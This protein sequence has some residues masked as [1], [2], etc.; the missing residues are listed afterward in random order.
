MVYLLQE[1]VLLRGA[2]E[3]AAQQTAPGSCGHSQNPPRF[4]LVYRKFIGLDSDFCN[5][6]FWPQENQ[7]IGVLE[8]GVRERGG[9]QDCRFFD[10]P[11]LVSLHFS[12]RQGDA[13]SPQRET[14][15]AFAFAEVPH[16][17]ADADSRALHCT[18]GTDLHIESVPR[19]GQGDRLR[20]AVS[21]PIRPEKT[22]PVGDPLDRIQRII[23][24]VLQNKLQGRAVSGSGT[25]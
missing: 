25:V 6:A 9:R 8:A 4:F 16:P 1:V 21:A 11:P 7:K 3:L 20:N 15:V 18:A 5:P 13:L 24:P 12:V 2:K 19:P 14:A 23:R 17:S 10:L 22:S